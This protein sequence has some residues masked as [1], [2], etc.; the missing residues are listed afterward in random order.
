[1]K[2]ALVVGFGGM[3]CR[4]AQSLLNS[5]EFDEI[6]ILEPNE[7]VFYKNLELIGATEDSNISRIQS[8]LDIKQK[9]EFI[10]IATL[11]DIRFK[12]FV[13]CLELKPK[14]ILLE[15]VV[16][17]SKKEFVSAIEFVKNHDIQVY[18][19]L[20]NRYFPNYK[21]IKNEGLD[22]K[23]MRVTGP[24][25]G[26][27]CNSVHYIDLVQ[28]LTGEIPISHV[29]S[30]G[31]SPSLNKRG[32]SY[33]EGQG[34]LT[35]ITKNG[36]VLEIVADSKMYTDVVVEIK[37]EQK[38]I[39]FNENQNLGNEILVGSA[40]QAEFLPV[41]ASILTAQAYSDML[42]GECLFPSLDEL[43]CSHDALFAAV[44]AL[45]GLQVDHLPI[46]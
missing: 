20:P 46:T 11:A 28:Y 34:T 15:K 16:F 25:F 36:I 12:Y 9:I 6:Y 1:M 5:S 21:K 27:L 43:N 26:L 33:I 32:D 19:N 30:M 31:W 18:G 39:R 3:G 40:V 14:Y 17:Q 42:R 29:S 7:D 37:T 35:F 22:L 8:L 41:F 45:T 13:E 23:A 2:N 10:I 4:H 24:D 38:I 44:K